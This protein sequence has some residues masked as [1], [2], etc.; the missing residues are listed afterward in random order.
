MAKTT[1]SQSS[2]E[3]MQ[4]QIK[5]SHFWALLAPITFLAGLGVGYVLWGSASAAAPAASGQTGSLPT[6]VAPVGQTG[7]GDTA[8]QIA[9]LPRYDVS[10]DADDPVL[11]DPDAPITIIE[12]ADFQC[13][14]C[15][16]HFQETYPQLIAQ[17]GDQIRFVF[18]N[19]PLRTLH[20]DAQSAAEAGECANE[21][22]KFWEYHDLLFGG[23]LGLGQ[24]AYEGYAEQ[25]GLDVAAL[26]ACI[27]EG[28]YAEAVDRD[29]ALGQQIG[30]SATPTFFVNGI[31]LEGAYP[32][33]TFAAVIDYELANQE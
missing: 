29:Y 7:A 9:N 6:A 24:A 8:S 33:D 16:R 15:I 27:E 23:T 28:R 10:I 31:A 13:P 3:V 4:F 11:G 25:L 14:F 19:F 1:R 17:Y 20:P 21:Q 18:K 22:G 32:F 12:F 26:T 2:D 5:R 30:V